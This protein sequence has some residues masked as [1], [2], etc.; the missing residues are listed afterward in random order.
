MPRRASRSTAP[1]SGRTTGHAPRSSSCDT[2]GQRPLTRS[3]A[4]LPLDAYFAA[5]KLRWLLDHAPDA[6][7]LARQGLLRLGTSDAFF[8]DRLCGVYATDITTASRTSLMNL[9]TGTWDPEL[10]RLFGVPIG[11]L[12]PIVPSVH[13]FGE[14]RGR[15]LSLTAAIV[16]QQA[17]LFGHGCHLPG[18]IKIT[19]GTGAFALAVAGDKPPAGDGGMLPTVAWRIGDRTAYAMDGG[20]YNA[21]SALN[22]VRGLG[23]FTDL[24]E[25]DSFQGPTALE[26]GL[27]FVPALSGLA[28]PY[29]DRSAAGL[30]LGMGLETTRDHMLQAVLEGIAMRSAQ[31]RC[32]P[33]RPPA[34]SR[35]T[36][37]RDT[38]CSPASPRERRRS[39]WRRNA[40][41]GRRA[42][43]PRTLR[44]LDEPSIPPEDD[45]ITRLIL[46]RTH[47]PAA[48][49]PIAH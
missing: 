8:L 24:R 41:A 20:V 9:A 31:A 43:R 29:W 14:I 49:A 19:F 47:D 10:C 44:F 2:T 21:A 25:I 22:W 42:A 40:R 17:A 12:P 3:R 11:L 37:G 34:R 32:S 35:A 16:D 27:A 7:R 23:L 36:K 39:A 28:C 5:S 30:W 48:F 15:G 1:S 4:G 18:D 13:P 6:R 45:E 33:R 46:V 26:R 38:G